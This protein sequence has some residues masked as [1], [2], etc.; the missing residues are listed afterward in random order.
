MSQLQRKFQPR[1]LVSNT[2]L[3]NS[4]PFEPYLLFSLLWHILAI[5]IE[6]L[7]QNKNGAS[8]LQS[9]I[10]ILYTKYILFYQDT[11]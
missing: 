11:H 10:I 4:K 6:W 8:L 2:E 7:S 5:P 3:D 1:T 9:G